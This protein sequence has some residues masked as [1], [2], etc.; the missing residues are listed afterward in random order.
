M[1]LVADQWQRST[2]RSP[3]LP[4]ARRS[5]NSTKSTLIRLRSTISRAMR[6]YGTTSGGGANDDGTVFKIR[7]GGVLT[8]LVEFTGVDNKGRQPEAGPDRRLELGHDRPAQG[9][10]LSR[11]LP[12]PVALQLP[13]PARYPG[14]NRIC[15]GRVDYP[16]QRVGKGMDYPPPARRHFPQRAGSYGR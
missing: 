6:N 5:G 9:C 1:G 12:A 7:P 15:T 2:T 3:A 8:T 14:K 13:G 16:G 4:L 10:H 11:H